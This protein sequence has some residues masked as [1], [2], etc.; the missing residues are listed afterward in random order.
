MVHL[1]RTVFVQ[2]H[3]GELGQVFK[4]WILVLSLY[5]SDGSS[6]SSALL[7]G[8]QVVQ[9]EREGGARK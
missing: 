4:L 8:G 3:R 9:E 2:H 5:D 1:V 7:S 6:W